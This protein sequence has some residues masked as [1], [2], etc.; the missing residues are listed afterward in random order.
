MRKITLSATCD[1]SGDA[2]TNSTQNILGKVYA[3]LY[4]PGTI[5]T[6]ATITVTSQGIFAKPILTQ[7]NAGTADILK[8]PRDLVHAV[9]DGAALTG[10][11]GG[12]R[13]MPLVNGSLR[14]VVASG[15]SGGIGSI[16]VYYED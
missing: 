1:S 5:A 9:A 10:T 8:Y 16:V 13:C 12:D 15:G 6:G 3:V 11:S 4:K 2:T 7:A 14:F